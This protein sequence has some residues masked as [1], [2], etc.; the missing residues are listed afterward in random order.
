MT[1]FADE[2]DNMLAGSRHVKI[3]LNWHK[4]G[5]TIQ[6]ILY[7]GVTTK[8][9]TNVDWVANKAQSGSGHVKISWAALLVET[10]EQKKGS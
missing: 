6:D 2:V 4:T 9:T 3:I 8:T 7:K 5:I 10:A 1:N